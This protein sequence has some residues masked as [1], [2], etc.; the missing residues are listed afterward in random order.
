MRNVESWPP[1]PESS[2]PPSQLARVAGVL[3]R[4]RRVERR[5]YVK[6]LCPDDLTGSHSLHSLRELQGNNRRASSR[7]YYTRIVVALKTSKT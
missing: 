4:Y 5:A 7:S 6:V 3:S 1:R 2:P